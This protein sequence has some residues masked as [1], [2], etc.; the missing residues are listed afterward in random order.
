MPSN[1]GLEI[2]IYSFE[3]E[4]G[5]KTVRDLSFIN[6][7]C[8]FTLKTGFHAHYLQYFTLCCIWCFENFPEMRRFFMDINGCSVK[9]LAVF[10]HS[11]E[12]TVYY[13]VQIVLL[14]VIE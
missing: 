12:R 8:Q 1:L 5:E 14:L 11:G 6:T 13:S 7:Y 3:V 9:I 10:P 2:V 4:E